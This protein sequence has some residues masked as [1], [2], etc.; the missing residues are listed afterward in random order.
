MLFRVSR[1]RRTD[2]PWFRMLIFSAGAVL[3]AAGIIFDIGWLVTVAIVVL[4]AGMVIG[5]IT[6]RRQEHTGDDDA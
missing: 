3:A 1:A 4:G 2:D 6:R 5:I